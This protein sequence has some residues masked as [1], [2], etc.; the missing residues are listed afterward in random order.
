MSAR[1]P[2]QRPPRADP[3]PVTTTEQVRGAVPAVADPIPSRRRRK[4][5][6][7][8]F[9]FR[10]P[11]KVSREHVR[12]LQIVHETFARQFTTIL[13]TT[14]RSV[15]T[16]TVASIDH[17]SYDEYVRSCPNPSFLAVLSLPPLPGV[18]VLQLPLPIAMAAVDRL[19]GGSGEAVQPERPLT[20]IE[21][22]LVRELVTRVL[23]ELDY[24][25]ETLAAIQTSIV[26]IEINPQFTQITAPS[27]IVVLASYDVRIGSQEHTASLCIPLAALMPTLES[28]TGRELFADHKG[29]D[30]AETGRAVSERLSRVPLEIVV[31]FDEVTLTSGEILGLQVG[32]VLPLR[33]P[34]SAPLSV[35]AAG[36]V[37]ARAVPG[38][39]GRQLAFLV[40]QS[41]DT[42]ST[43]EDHRR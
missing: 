4:S 41:D 31:R 10:R 26:A 9:D 29:F 16:V 1:T 21:T 28:M 7:Q 33:H 34:V 18:G 27:D 19:L 14:L 15:C 43:D 23:R 17:L 36:Q 30:A 6:P 38:S 11:N 22:M 24:A 39:K 25:L 20:D 13:S 2:H 8:P 42:P 32:D 35:T 5:G 37:L 3:C 12:A 40:V